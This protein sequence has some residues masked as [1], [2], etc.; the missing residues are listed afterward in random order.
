M[1]VLTH[2]CPP[3]FPLQTKATAMAEMFHAPN[4]AEGWV[5]FN[6]G[7]VCFVKDNIKRSY[8]IRLFHLTVSYVHE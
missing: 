1:F 8:F 5:K 3:S 6:E 2:I 4:D 7:V